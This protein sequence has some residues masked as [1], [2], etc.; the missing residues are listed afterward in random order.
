MHFMERACLL[1]A[2]MSRRRR[3]WRGWS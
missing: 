1:H 3:S 2:K